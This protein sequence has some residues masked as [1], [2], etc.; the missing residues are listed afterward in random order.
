MTYGAGILVDDS[1]GIGHNGTVI[2]FHAD[3]WHDPHTQTTVAVLCNTNAPIL[4]DER[5]PTREIAQEVLLRFKRMA[6]DE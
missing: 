4:D 6:V 1:F 2:G 5:D 3:A